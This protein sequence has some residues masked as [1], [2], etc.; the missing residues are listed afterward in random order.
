MENTTATPLTMDEFIDVVD[1]VSAGLQTE[2]IDHDGMI[3]S[4]FKRH[5]D[6]G[7]IVL[8][9]GQ[10][11]GGFMIHQTE[12]EMLAVCNTVSKITHEQFA[13]IISEVDEAGGTVE[14]STHAGIDVHG[15]YHPRMGKVTLVSNPFSGAGFIIRTS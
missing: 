6:Y 10:E 4:I 12:G 8:V 3:V 9:S 14:R 13:N 15:V 2:Q 1:T 5:P 7:N 11:E